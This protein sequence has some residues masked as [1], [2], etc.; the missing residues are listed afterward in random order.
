M[1]ITAAIPTAPTVCGCLKIGSQSNAHAHI[2]M[3]VF[4]AFLPVEFRKR[5]L[6]QVASDSPR[7]RHTHTQTHVDWLRAAHHW[8]APTLHPGS[9]LI[10]TY[11][12]LSIAVRWLTHKWHTH[13]DGRYGGIAFTSQQPIFSPHTNRHTLQSLTYIAQHNIRFQH[14]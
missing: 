4:R 2:G 8:S 9:Q 7:T 6:I 12:Y 14:T 11:P 3:F 13:P 5:I 10:K 1:T